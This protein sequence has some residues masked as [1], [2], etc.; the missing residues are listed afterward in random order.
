MLLLRRGRP[1]QSLGSRLDIE[2]PF[3]WGLE[4]GGQRAE[5]P[6]PWRP[7]IEVI[8]C[9]EALLVRVEIAGLSHADLNVMV[10]GDELRVRGERTVA[11]LVGSR[12][13]HESRIRYGPFEA[14]VRLP[15]PIA[16]QEASADYIDGFLSVR[17][18]RLTA[19]KVPLRHPSR[20]RETDGG[21]Q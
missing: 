3:D 20:A 16:V 10:V 11:Q 19:A 4:Q 5:F 13:Y 12:L 18:P 8:E 9:A 21:E 17:L 6:K 2:I 7:P 15:F 14:A 1:V